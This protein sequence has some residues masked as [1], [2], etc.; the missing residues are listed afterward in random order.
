MIEEANRK[1][2]DMTPTGDISFNIVQMMAGEES[3]T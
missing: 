3:K 2:I 1:S